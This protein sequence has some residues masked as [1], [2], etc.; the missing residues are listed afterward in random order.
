MLPL[1]VRRNMVRHGMRLTSNFKRLVASVGALGV[2]TV[3][4]CSSPAPA[5]PPPTQ[6]AQTGGLVARAAS[7]DLG[8]VPF[9]VQ[10]EGRFEL[11]NTSA[12]PVKLAVPPKVTM[13]EGC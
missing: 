5:S 2:L 8:R 9:N 7:V 1:I 11:V 3:V 4:G 6:G 13:L 12:R 10:A